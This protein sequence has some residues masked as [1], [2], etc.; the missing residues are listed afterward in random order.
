M[1]V[2]TR[3]AFNHDGCVS[4]TLDALMGLNLI[5][6][7]LSRSNIFLRFSFSAFNRTISDMTDYLHAFILL[8]G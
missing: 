3:A 7:D 5:S 6:N 1:R 2:D 8:R 4:I